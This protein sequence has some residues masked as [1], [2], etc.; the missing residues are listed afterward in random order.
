MSGRQTPPPRLAVPVLGAGLCAKTGPR[1]RHRI[2]G[3]RGL[4]SALLRR[5]ACSYPRA[6]PALLSPPHDKLQPSCVARVVGI[7]SGIFLMFVLS[8]VFFPR[9][10]S[11]KA[12]A[13]TKWVL[14]CC[15]KACL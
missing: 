5:R 13:A 14:G 8:M 9:A 11:D 2:S 12:R 7:L 1:R 3:K 10:A 6:A 15:D 4:C